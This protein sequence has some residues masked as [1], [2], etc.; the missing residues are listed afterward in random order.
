MKFYTQW[1]KPDRQFEKVDPVSV[2]ET[3]GY[4]PSEIQIMDMLAAGRQLGE[5][6]RERYDF[7][8]GED[9]PADYSDPTRSYGFDMADAS[10]MG[11]EARARIKASAAEAAAQAK[12]A[13]S[14]VSKDDG[15]KV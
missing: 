13:E 10:A 4:I 12:L 11:R 15:D 3:S 5:I 14:S 7:G 9:V 1:R 8:P 6:R 2:V